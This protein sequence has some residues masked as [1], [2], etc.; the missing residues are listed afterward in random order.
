MYTLE[1]IV[2][3]I[4]MC[5]RMSTPEAIEFKTR[6]GLFAGKT[7]SKEDNKVNKLQEIYIPPEK[8]QQII[9]GLRLF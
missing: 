2:T 3:P 1:D 8:C 9:D 5:C 4:I 6:L 7:K